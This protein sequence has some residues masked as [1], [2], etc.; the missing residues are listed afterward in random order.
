MSGQ[1]LVAIR[2]ARSGSGA[3]IASIK[4][5]ISIILCPLYQLVIASYLDVIK[6]LKVKGR[7]GGDAAMDEI[8]VLDNHSMLAY[9]RKTSRTTN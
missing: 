2:R 6:A 8:N 7:H 4:R 5:S 3:D 9:R 1:D